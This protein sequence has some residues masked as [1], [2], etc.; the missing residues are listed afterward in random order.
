MVCFFR[1][2]LLLSLGILNVG[3]SQLE[4]QD[5]STSLLEEKIPYVRGWLCE[6]Q[7]S[8]GRALL[9]FK[10]QETPFSPKW[11]RAAPSI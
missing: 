6:A 9:G 1:S 10:V 4:A 11:L 5:P 2:M 3:H 7:H 8:P